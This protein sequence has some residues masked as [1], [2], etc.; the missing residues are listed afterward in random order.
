MLEKFEL[1]N[2]HF[3]YPTYDNL[4]FRST[5]KHI[6]EYAALSRDCGSDL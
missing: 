5:G 6:S 4:V 3:S 1:F 2:I